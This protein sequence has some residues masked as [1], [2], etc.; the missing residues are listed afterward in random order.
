MSPR[1]AEFM[2]WAGRI[3]EPSSPRRF[4]IGGSRG[5]C[6]RQFC[7]RLP[8]FGQ[9]GLGNRRRRVGLFRPRRDDWTL[10]RAAGLGCRDRNTHLSGV[11]VSVAQ[12]LGDDLRHEPVAAGDAH[13]RRPVGVVHILYPAMAGFVREYYNHALL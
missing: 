7:N 6:G 12:D 10:A 4:V 9:S 11:F 1:W 2:A 8:L 3:S 5:F 13:G